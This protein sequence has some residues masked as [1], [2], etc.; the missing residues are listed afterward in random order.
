MQECFQIKSADD[1]IKILEKDG[2]SPPLYDFDYQL[3]T[4]Y[5]LVF[6]L[7]NNKVIFLPNNFRDK[8]LIF[9]DNNCFKQVIHADKFPLENPERTLYDT[10]IEGIKIINEQIGFYHSHLN[11]ILKFDYPEINQEIAQLYL[12][13]I[14]GRTIKKLT[15]HKDIIAL[16]AVLGELIRKEVNGKWVI[17]KWYGTYNPHFKPRILNNKQRLIFI[18]D[19]ILSQIKWKVS[20]TQYILGSAHVKEGLILMSKRSEQHECIILGN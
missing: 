13:K 10:E 5:G 15:T 1:L 4:N 7:T 16:I 17:E 18:D 12:K 20:D 9:E 2:K 6:N 3:Q 14:I 11:T 19:I 8:G